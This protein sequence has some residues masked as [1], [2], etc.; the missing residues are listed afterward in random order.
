MNNQK[1]AYKIIKDGLIEI[2]KEDVLNMNMNI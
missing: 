2:I 1:E